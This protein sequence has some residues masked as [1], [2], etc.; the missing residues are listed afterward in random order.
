LLTLS[1]GFVHGLRKNLFVVL[2]GQ[3]M[4][5]RKHAADVDLATLEHVQDLRK[6][7]RRTH[8]PNELAR[9]GLGHMKAL[10][11]EREHRRACL[12]RPELTSVD[13]VDAHQELT[14]GCALL[15]HQCG[16]SLEKV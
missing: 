5:E 6:C 15:L 14:R 1:L 12:L 9:L 11:A 16:E 4:H 13:F 7:S 10:N 8:D 2:F 3:A